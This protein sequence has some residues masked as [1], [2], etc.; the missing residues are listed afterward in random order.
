M[1]LVQQ[2]VRAKFNDSIRIVFSSDRQYLPFLATAIASLVEH[3][4]TSKRYEIFVL[5]DGILPFEQKLVAPLAP[6]HITIEFIDIRAYLDGINRS[7]FY[8]HAYL[9]IASYYRFFVPRIFP[10]FDKVV[11]LDCDI[12]VLDD[13][14]RLY[15]TDV[16]KHILAAAPDVDKI[17]LFHTDPAQF[18][19]Y[20]KQ[21]HIRKPLDYFQAGVLVMNIRKMLEEN[22]EQKA[23][24]RLAL[25]KDPPSVDQDVLNS[26]YSDHYKRLPVAWN[27]EWH[28]PPMGYL[29]SLKRNTTPELYEEYSSAYADPSIIHYCSNLKPWQDPKQQ[30]SAQFWHYARK[31]PFYEVILYGFNG[32]D[33]K[34]GQ[35]GKKRKMKIRHLKYAVL[36]RLTTGPL[37]RKYL[38]KKA[39][40]ADR[41][42]NATD[43]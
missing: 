29:D 8:V 27:V 23:L 39:V 37:R 11:Y 35:R 5:H 12:I 1:S 14:A 17:R 7:V 34:T 36:S 42:K 24:E 38:A 22:F 10:S 18:E 33:S 9:T 19:R 4:D 20:H 30:Y 21:Y 28:L 2:P 15:D 41:L 13:V 31:T 26:L 32:G 6:P 40:L 3:S 43:S 16:G 25:L